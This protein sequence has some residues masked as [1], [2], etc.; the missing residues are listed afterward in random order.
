MKKIS[1]IFGILFSFTVTMILPSCKT[2]V[3][4]TNEQRVEAA[5][6]GFVAR[7]VQNPPTTADIS[8]RVK[9]YLQANRSFFYG[10]TV[11]LLDSTGLA[12]VSP[13]WYRAGSD[14]S[15]VDLAVDSAYH[16][17]EQSWLRAPID[18]GR[19][20]WTDPYFDAGGG[21]IMMK[22][23]SVPVFVNGKIIAV[24]TTDLAL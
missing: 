8:G 5:L 2:E 4:L 21:E 15:F 17:N 22:T 11:T 10:S 3:A 7:L 9:D 1:L 14:L 13:Y 6:D 20:I 24:A 23:R 19:A 12:T 18:G 16:I